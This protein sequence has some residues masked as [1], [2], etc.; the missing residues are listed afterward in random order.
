L[1]NGRV[2]ERNRIEKQ[3]CVGLFPVGR[4]LKSRHHHSGPTLIEF[5][6]NPH[7]FFVLGFQK[8][9]FQSIL[10]S[11]IILVRSNRSIPNIFVSFL[12]L[13]H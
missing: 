8:Q 10:N 13:R 12:D 7:I 3:R 4:I 11:K 1:A 6:K 9:N 5:E 2:L